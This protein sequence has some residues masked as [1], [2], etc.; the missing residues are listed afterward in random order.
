MSDIPVANYERV[1]G[2]KKR[3]INIAY[4]RNPDATI[5]KPVGITLVDDDGRPI[6]KVNAFHKNKLY[7]QA[8]DLRTKLRE[9]LP[10]KSEHWNPTKENVLKV[11]HQEIKNKDIKR[12]KMAM[13][14]IGADPHDY[15]MEK[16]RRGR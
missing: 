6:R 2:K 3:D 7:R 15:N 16:I 10:T 11:L 12:Y 9:E 5:N 4:K 13:K 1:F 8:K 14:A